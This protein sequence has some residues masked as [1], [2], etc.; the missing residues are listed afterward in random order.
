[1]VSFICGRRG[2]ATRRYE[3]LP[4]RISK[5]S[6][7]PTTQPLVRI[8]YTTRACSEAPIATAPSGAAKFELC[9]ALCSPRYCAASCYAAENRAVSGYLDLST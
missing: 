8:G 5:P 6:A 3:A 2:S 1:M 4:R 7:Q 9:K